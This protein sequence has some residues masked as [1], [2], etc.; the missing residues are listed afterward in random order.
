[1]QSFRVSAD[2]PAYGTASADESKKFTKLK[3][4]II[5]AVWIAVALHSAEVRVV[6]RRRISIVEEGS[7]KTSIVA[8]AIIAAMLCAVRPAQAQVVADTGQNWRYQYQDGRWWYWMPDNHWVYW[9]NG[10]WI[11]YSPGVATQTYQNAQPVP[12][13]S[14]Y[15]GYDS[16]YYTS[17]GYYYGGYPSWGYGGYYGGAG[18]GIGIGGGWGGRGWGGGGWG[19]GGR[20]RR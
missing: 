10:S 2:F 20:G 14:G 7:M 5:R 1:M 4:S 15:G 19:G 3:G 8:I 12:Y 9:D 11:D 16:G 13:T 18:V 17:P 6:D